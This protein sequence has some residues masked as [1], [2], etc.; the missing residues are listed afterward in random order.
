M[1]IGEIRSGGAYRPSIL[2]D[3][4]EAIIGAIYLD[5]NDMAVCYKVVSFL[6]RNRLNSVSLEQ[7]FKDPK[8][9]LQEIVQSHQLEL[10]EYKLVQKKGKEHQ[11]MFVVECHI[12]MLPKPTVG[13]GTS[14][15]RA[16]QTAARKALTAIGELKE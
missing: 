10:P 1:G 12:G 11:Q 6:Y 15:R 13:E 4:I 9:W 2:S 16:E 3:T 7:Q 5:S 14:R 8:S